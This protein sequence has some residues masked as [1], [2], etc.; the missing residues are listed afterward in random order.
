MNFNSLS[1]NYL[2]IQNYVQ[3]DL[4]IRPIKMDLIH[5]ETDRGNKCLIY[6][7]FTYRKVNVL[8]NGDVVYR[9]SSEKTCKAGIVTDKDGLG[10]IKIRNEHKN[11]T[12]KA[13]RKRR[14][15]NS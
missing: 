6:N 11:V 2:V 13:V 5:T 8:K 7:N 1:P 3:F 15:L 9:C 12:T 4:N 10:V 14:K